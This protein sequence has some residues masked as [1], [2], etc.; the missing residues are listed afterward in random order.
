MR[1]L[2][3]CT[4]TIIL[5]FT[6]V[7]VAVAAE[8]QPWSENVFT[9]VEKEFG[10]QAAKRLRYLHKMVMDN[11][12]LPVMEKLVLVNRTLNHLPWIADSEHWKQADYWATPM[13]TIATFGGD[14]EDIAIVKWV[15]LNHLG[16]SSKNLRLA[17][18]K[19]KRTGESHMV[20][21][22]I[23][24]PD[25]PPEQQKGWVLDNYIDEV[26]RGKERMDLLA[27]YLTDANGNLALIEDT[28]TERSLKGVFKERK[29]KKLEDL[30][31]KIAEGRVRYQKLNDGRPL[32]PPEPK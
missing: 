15:T 5:A 22:Y 7:S 28:G 6:S 29:M 16:I 31:K 21:V 2:Y 10:P 27:V 18:A 23:E 30:K 20:L 19:I 26:K 12:N 9:H 17:Y 4:L 8:Y 32:L 1:I 3:L 24:N 14:C 25:D 11:Q 13:E